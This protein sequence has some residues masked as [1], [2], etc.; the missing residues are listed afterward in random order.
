MSDY[1][2]I[3]EQV[4]GLLAKFTSGRIEDNTRAI[5]D[6]FDEAMQQLLVPKPGVKLRQWPE[7]SKTLNGIR[8][9]EFSILCGPTGS[10]KTMLLANLAAMLVDAGAVCHVAP[11]ETGA[12]D[13]IHRMMGI[14]AGRELS[15]ADGISEASAK[16]IA[17]RFK[18][19]FYGRK[20][21]LSTYETRVSHRQ[22]MCDIYKSY[23]M[24]GATVFLLDNLNFM[25]EITNAR[26]S[27][28]EMDRV[29]HDLVVFCKLLPIHIVMVMHPKKTDGG[30]VESEFDIKGSSTAVQEAS[31]VMLWNRLPDGKMIAR[32]H[33]R[34][35]YRE[36]K[37][38]KI[39]KNGKF[40]GSRI[41]YKREVSSE[42]LREVTL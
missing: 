35:F 22:I 21:V 26:D 1:L 25:L 41:Y 29:I 40:T 13:F 31:N 36:L 42:N 34:S 9:H 33:E 14:Y 20:L 32:E 17:S 19:T 27:V 15:V 7:F 16:D 2:E 12:H 11:V 39:R 37:F 10:G 6:L 28:S 38:C 24:R 5:G 23:F 3:S 4:D 18:E 8:A 30:R